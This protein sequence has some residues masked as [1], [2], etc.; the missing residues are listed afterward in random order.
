MSEREPDAAL[1]NYFDDLLG[2]EAR[3]NAVEANGLKKPVG[4]I[5]SI[6]ASMPFKSAVKEEPID[7]ALVVETAIAEPEPLSEKKA[8]LQKLL[9]GARLDVEQIVD[10]PD[11]SDSPEILEAIEADFAVD[12]TVE[13]FSEI[14]VLQALLA[15]NENGR[16][17]WAQKEFDAL[18]F[19]VSGLTLAVPLIALGQIQPLNDELTP[20][21]GQADWFMGIQ[22]TPNGKVRTVNTAKFVMPERYDESFLETAKYVVSINGVPW[23]LA[24]DAVKQP[25]VL[26]PDD[27][28]WRTGRTQRP[29]LA[30]TVKKEMCALLD[31]PA[32]GQMLVDNDQNAGPS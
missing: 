2:L 32:I 20:L 7:I 6:V 8:Q 9:L 19:T 31:I 22:P 3:S 11:V 27:V 17:E 14:Q 24:V 26:K 18:L 21:F 5:E 30:G 16:P 25:I 28:K 29:W 1:Q 12:S 15:W 4:S 10:E 23:G 13:E